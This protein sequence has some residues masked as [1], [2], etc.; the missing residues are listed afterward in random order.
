[1]NLCT[2]QVK[3]RRNGGEI[4]RVPLLLIHFAFE[5][6]APSFQKSAKALGARYDVGAAFAV[7]TTAKQTSPDCETLAL[8]CADQCRSEITECPAHD[9]NR[10]CE[11]ELNRNLQS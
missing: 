7:T 1:M 9:P 8:A 11:R 5:R 4:A 3:S 6:A 2:S 10:G